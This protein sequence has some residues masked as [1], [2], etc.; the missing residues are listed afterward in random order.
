MM[1]A[2][3]GMSIGSINPA[4]GWAIEKS[5]QESDEIEVELSK[6]RFRSRTESPHQQRS[7]RGG[8][9]QQEQLIGQLIEPNSSSE[10]PTPPSAGGFGCRRESRRVGSVPVDHLPPT[11]PCS[12]TV[13]GAV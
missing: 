9:R 7:T 5:E 1:F 10:P 8:D 13:A 3:G 6:R 4:A 12:E 11:K 2:N